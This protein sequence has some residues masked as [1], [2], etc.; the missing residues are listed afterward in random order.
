VPTDSDVA[1][2]PALWID[3]VVINDKEH[4]GIVLGGLTKKKG[5]GF[6]L[7]IST[8]KEFGMKFIPKTLG[9]F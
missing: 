4:L 3:I 2:Q 7:T 5:A 9:D 8:P 6:T 1:I